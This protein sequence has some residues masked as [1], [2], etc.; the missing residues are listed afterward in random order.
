[1]ELIPAEC[2]CPESTLVIYTP[3]IPADHKEW[4]LFR[5]G[6]FTIMKRAEVLGIITKGKRGVCAM[7]F[8]ATMEYVMRQKGISASELSRM[9]GIGRQYFTEL[10]RLFLTRYQGKRWTM[11]PKVRKTGVFRNAM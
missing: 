8:Y 9:T 10:K 1:M 3:A 11:R 7:S 6:G 4:P 5:N 2:K